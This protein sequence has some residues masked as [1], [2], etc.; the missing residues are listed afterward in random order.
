M[1]WSALVSFLLF[2]PFGWWILF[3]LA[4]VVLSPI[5]YRVRGWLR[6][7]RFLAS[8]SVRLAN[9]QNAEVRRDLA[10]LYF[11]SGRSRKAER[12]AREA[13]EVARSNPLYE[14]KGPDPFHRLWAA[15][16]YRLKRYEQAIAAYDEALKSRSETGYFDALLGMAKTHWRLGNV[17]MAM[18]WAKHAVQE[19]TSSLEGYFRWAQAAAKA[20]RPEEVA[21]ARLGFAKTRAALPRFARERKIRWTLAFWFFPLSR[22]VV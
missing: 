4:M 13:I 12:F 1:F 15:A 19:N 6:E 18:K 10:D 8:Q 11:S 14:G 7:R 21:E 16:L 9:P 2:S 3:M 5:G 20:G 17:D 22:R